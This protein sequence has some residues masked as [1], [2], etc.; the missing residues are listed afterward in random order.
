MKEAVED[1]MEHDMYLCPA[2]L[3]AL[4]FLNDARFLS[5][6]KALVEQSVRPIQKG[7][8]KVYQKHYF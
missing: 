4:S 7:S 5:H 6:D 8:V 3:C 1:S 2:Q